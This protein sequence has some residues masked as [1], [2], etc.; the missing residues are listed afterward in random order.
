MNETKLTH[1]ND[2]GE[3]HM[4]DVGQKKTTHRQASASGQIK[5]HPVTLKLISDRGH[6]KGDVLA[7][8]RVA[9]IMAAKKTADMIPLCH[10]LFLTRIDVDFQLDESAGSVVCSVIA[11]T[12]EKTGVEIEALNAVSIGLL[13]IYDMCKAVDRGMQITDIQLDKKSGGQSGT[14]TRK[15]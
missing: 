11:E 7:I 3:A 6:P 9:A 4:V 8:A 5:M 13:T 1:L 15:S 2:R 10:S 14:W 12:Y